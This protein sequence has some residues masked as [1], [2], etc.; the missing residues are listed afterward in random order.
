MQQSEQSANREMPVEALVELLVEQAADIPGGGFW[1][2]EIVT[3]ERW[4]HLAPHQ[5]GARQ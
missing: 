3:P 5:A 4:R 1:Q 2:A